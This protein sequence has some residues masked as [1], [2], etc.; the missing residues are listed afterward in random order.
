MRIGVYTACYGRV[1]Y[2]VR[3][4]DDWRCARDPHRLV[5]RNMRSRFTAWATENNRE[6][7][8]VKLPKLLYGRLGVIHLE[9]YYTRTALRKCTY[10][11]V[12]HVLS[13]CIQ[14]REILIITTDRVPT[15]ATTARTYWN[16][17][18]LFATI[19]AFIY[20]YPWAW[21]VYTESTRLT[22]ARTPPISG[23]GKDVII[24]RRSQNIDEVRA[25]DY[26]SKVKIDKIVTYTHHSC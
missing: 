25:R 21:P 11:A 13:C 24:T 22:C 9:L 2:T 6:K 7:C 20:L 26:K 10:R 4:R 18:Y 3:Y 1:W 15:M 16:R 23:L 5:C 8:R 19:R 17:E 12:A 14:L